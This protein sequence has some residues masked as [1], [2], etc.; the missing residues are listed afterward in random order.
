MLRIRIPCSMPRKTYDAVSLDQVHE[1]SHRQLNH[2]YTA[3]EENV[4]E[5]QKI[6][7]NSLRY[8]LFSDINRLT[9]KSEYVLQN[10][11]RQLTLPPSFLF[12]PALLPRQS[13]GGGPKE[14]QAEQSSQFFFK[15]PFVS[16]P[17]PHV[18]FRDSFGS[19]TYV[20]DALESASQTS[21]K[22]A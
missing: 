12:A 7:S 16:D 5:K 22:R 4:K 17:F 9:T 6:Y 14:K 11:G 2:V 10:R 3:S 19:R 21:R 1:Q 15:T 20:L 13:A 8:I 18:Q